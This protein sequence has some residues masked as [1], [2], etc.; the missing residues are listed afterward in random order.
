MLW[1]MSRGSRHVFASDRR[2]L[3]MGITF[4]ITE[5]HSIEEALRTFGG[6]LIEAQEQERKRISRELHDDISQQLAL[7]SVGLQQ[8]QSAEDLKPAERRMRI[9][10]LRIET[11]SLAAEVQTLSRQLHSSKL[12]Y[13]GLV[14]AIRALCK[15]ISAHHQAEI[16]FMQS[17]LPKSMPPDVALAL[18]RITQESLHN[19]VKYSGVRDFTVRLRGTETHIELVISDQGVGFDVSLA[20]Q[21]RGLGLISMRERIIALKGT[22]SIESQPM[23]G[24][25]VSVRVPLG[26]DGAA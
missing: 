19:A 25:Q 20:K 26:A 11:M 23:K 15:E 10:K 14:P 2:S 4:D 18:F 8:L 5:R 7:I 16:N 13:L 6:R 1:V 22:L 9:E 24:T 12:E 21:S 17:N 3:L